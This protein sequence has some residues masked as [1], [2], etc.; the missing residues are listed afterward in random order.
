MLAYEITILCMCVSLQILY[1]L[2]DFH[3]IL[4]ER[5]DFGG[6]PNLKLFNIYNE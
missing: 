5:Y 1:Q 3:K 4:Y 2:T 6:N